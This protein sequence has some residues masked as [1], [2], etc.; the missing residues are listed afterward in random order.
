[1][2]SGEQQGPGGRKG[3][4]VEDIFRDAVS[5]VKTP[6]LQSECRGEVSSLESKGKRVQVDGTSRCWG[7]WLGYS[8]NSKQANEAACEPGGWR[9]N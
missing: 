4:L 6:D 5:E 8:R 9:G 3:V 1:M 7:T 2:G